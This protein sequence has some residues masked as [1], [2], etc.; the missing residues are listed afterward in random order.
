MHEVLREKEDLQ[1]MG[2]HILVMM[3]DLDNYSLCCSS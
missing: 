3:D 1:G 2:E